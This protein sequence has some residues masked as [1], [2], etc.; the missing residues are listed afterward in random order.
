MPPHA[1]SDRHALLSDLDGVLVNSQRSA[2]RAWR[3]WAESHG[4]DPTPF[5][6]AHGL[7]AVEMIRTLGPSTFG[8]RLHQE[9][10]SV[11]DHEIL[12]TGDVT[13]HDGAAELLGTSLPVAVV[14]SAV[15]NLAKARLHAAGLRPPNVV[16]GADT[17][18][19]HKPHPAPY[20][21]AAH[22]LGVAPQLCVAFEDTPTG[23]KAAREAGMHVVGVSTTLDPADLHEAHTIVPSLTDY[24]ESASYSRVSGEGST[25]A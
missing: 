15:T 12:D 24:L 21:L 7:S 3:R 9:A 1:R 4:L 18:S 25:C 10:A 16:I 14:T 11:S 8:Q 13:A 17:V 6:T 5:L 23:I 19:D 20:L 22:R 2:R